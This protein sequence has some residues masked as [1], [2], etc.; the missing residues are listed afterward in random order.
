MEVD[1]I[2]NNILINAADYYPQA[3]VSGGTP[4]MRE[5]ITDVD[6]VDDPDND[7]LFNSKV[8]INNYV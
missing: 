5:T 3:P 6:R 1:N 4:R 2:V 7:L 8:R